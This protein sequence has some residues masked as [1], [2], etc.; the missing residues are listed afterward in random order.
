MKTRVFALFTLLLMAILPSIAQDQNALKHI[1]LNNT[2]FSYPAVLGPHI[3]ITT[4]EGDPLDQP[5]PSE[6]MGWEAAYTQFELYGERTSRP[7]F[8][9]RLVRTADLVGYP[10]EKTF[11]ALQELLKTH[12]D[13][14][15]Y[16]AGARGG[17]T[18]LLPR[19][20]GA[21][22]VQIF[23]A[24]AEY[25]ETETFE[26]IGYVTAYV[27]DTFPFHSD[28]FQ[29]DILGVSKDGSTYVWMRTFLHTDLFPE[30]SEIESDS[31]SQEFYTDIDAYFQHSI[32]TINAAPADAFTPSLDELAALVASLR[33]DEGE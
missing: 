14:K 5:P 32:E 28:L 17:L 7:H 26:G 12:P 6:M 31:A 24:R 29:Y 30:F 19:P 3:T 16:E 23:I 20:P 27:Q 4:Y 9:M 25:L 22:S 18:R 2:S 21:G 11:M 13:L 33:I 1:A 10:E 15:T 8:W